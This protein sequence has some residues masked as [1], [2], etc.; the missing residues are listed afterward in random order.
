MGARFGARLRAIRQS[1]GLSLSAVSERTGWC[2][3]YLCEIESSKKRPPKPS[4]LKVLLQAMQADEYL[5][6]ML[7][8]AAESRIPVARLIRDE[9]DAEVARAVIELGKALMDGRMTLETARQITRLLKE[10]HGIMV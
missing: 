10:G 3:S 4:R 7:D 1:R 2:P 5:A 9:V 6:E 8:L